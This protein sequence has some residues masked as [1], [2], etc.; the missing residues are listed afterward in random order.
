MLKLGFGQPDIATSAQAEGAH[1]LGQSALDPSPFAVPGT[2]S[3][4]FLLA[5]NGLQGF[6]Q[7][8]R[9]QRDFAGVGLGSGAEGAAATSGTG[10]AVKPDVDRVVTPRIAGRRPVD[11]GLAGRAD[12][13]FG[14]PVDGV[15]PAL[16]DS[17]GEF[18]I[19]RSAVPGCERKSIFEF[20]PA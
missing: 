9:T 17:V 13:L 5:A 11:A 10:G 4:R 16:L 3:F 6:M 18:R 19:R 2:P 7:R 1:R 15:L 20:F 14:L 8:A 12:H